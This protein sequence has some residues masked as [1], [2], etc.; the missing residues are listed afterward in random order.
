MRDYVRQVVLG[1]A[2]ALSLIA[3][4]LGCGDGAPPPSGTLSLLVDADR[5]GRASASEGDR[6]R[7]A[8]FSSAF[9]ATLLANLDDDDGDRVRDALDEIV[10]GQEDEIDLARI[11]LPP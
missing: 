11:V 6:A 7:K 3:G 10:N 4:L 9:G 2:T 1:H 5:D 8:E